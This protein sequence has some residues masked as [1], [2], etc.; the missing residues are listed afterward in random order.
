MSESESSMYYDLIK[1]AAKNR[2]WLEFECECAEEIAKIYSD[3][4]IFNSY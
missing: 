3:K 1:N 2:E 4:F